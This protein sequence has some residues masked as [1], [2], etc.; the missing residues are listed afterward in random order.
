MDGFKDLADAL[1][2]ASGGG[3]TSDYQ[4]WNYYQWTLYKIM[5]YTVMGSKNAQVMVD[6]GYTRGGTEGSEGNESCAV[7]GSTDG[8]GF[9]GAAEE[10]R[11]ADGKVSSENGRT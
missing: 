9:A 6:A 3:P 1:T 10:T 2:P 11:S 8:I 5:C 4:Q 7:T